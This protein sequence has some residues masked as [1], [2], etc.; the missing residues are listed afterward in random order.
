MFVSH[1]P[2]DKRADDQHQEILDACKE[3]DVR[4][5]QRGVRAHINHTV[6]EL[7]KF[8]KEQETKA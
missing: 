1:Q 7:R 5:A 3:A 2:M 6:K 4:R 8:L